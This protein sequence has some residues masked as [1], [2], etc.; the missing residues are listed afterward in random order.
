MDRYN[1]QTLTHQDSVPNIRTVGAK[2]VYTWKI[3]GKTSKPSV[4]KVRWAA[5][6]YSQKKEWIP[7]SSL[8]QLPKKTPFDY[9][10]PLWTTTTGRWMIWTLW[11]LFW[12]EISRKQS[13]WDHQKAQVSQAA[14]CNSVTTPFPAGFKPFPATED[15]FKIAKDLPYAQLVGP[16]AYLL[17]DSLKSK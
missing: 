5:K 3:D 11:P 10:W 14:N 17:W 2:G 6:G 7:M 8:Q 15:E 12:I 13:I 9:L 4:Y 16:I 1:V